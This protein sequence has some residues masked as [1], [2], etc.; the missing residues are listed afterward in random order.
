MAMLGRPSFMPGGSMVGIWLSIKEKIM[1]RAA[2]RPS[3]VS[4]EVFIS[5]AHPTISTKSSPPLTTVTVN[6]LGRQV[7]VSPVLRMEPWFMQ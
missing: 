5:A 1:A 7:M 6:L 4:L 2:Q 3:I